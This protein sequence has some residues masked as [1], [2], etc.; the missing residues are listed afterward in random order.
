[1]ATITVRAAVRF[2]QPCDW[3][4][5]SSWDQETVWAGDLIDDFGSWVKPP[6]YLANGL[7]TIQTARPG[8]T[9][10]RSRGGAFETEEFTLYQAEAQWTLERKMIH[11][12]YGWG[13][14]SFGIVPV[15]R[16]LC[17]EIDSILRGAFGSDGFL[18]LIAPEVTV[19][20]RDADLHVV[21]GAEE[22]A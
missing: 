4:H 22:E 14:V 8:S 7:V 19:E 1:M 6:T 20:Y 12:D 2:A 10:P 21:V 17:Y 16:T 13:E 9:F 5:P 3:A 15:L 11:P 18:L